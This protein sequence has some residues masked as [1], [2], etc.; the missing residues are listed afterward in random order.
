MFWSGDEFNSSFSV[1]LKLSW[2][3]EKIS[4]LRAFSLLNWKRISDKAGIRLL[5]DTGKH[6]TPVNLMVICIVWIKA[7][8]LLLLFAW[9]C[10]WPDQAPLLAGW[11]RVNDS[12]TEGMEVNGDEGR[13]MDG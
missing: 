3:S 4:S 11:I 6:L 5:K 2:C 8:L 10:S 9:S 1:A 7:L 13:T 12:K